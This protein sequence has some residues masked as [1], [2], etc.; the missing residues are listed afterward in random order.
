MC[1]HCCGIIKP[2]DAEG[3]QLGKVLAAAD[4][5]DNV[6]SVEAELSALKAQVNQMMVANSTGDLQQR[7]PFEGRVQP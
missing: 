1:Y 4:G 3:L 7:R 2:M 5:G 6:A